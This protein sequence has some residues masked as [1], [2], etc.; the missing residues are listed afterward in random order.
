M[1]LVESILTK[2]PCY[3]AG[4]KID[5]KGLMLHSV[6]CSQPRASAFI[7][8]W[9]SPTFSRACV[10]G[11]IDGNDGTVYQ[12]LPWNHR[13]WHCGSSINGSG[14]NTHIGVEM[15]E[16]ACITYTGGATF[17]CS[18]VDTAKAVAE[19]TYRAAVELFAMLCQKFA[20]D[21]LADGVILSHKEGHSRGIASNHGDPEHL[22]SQLGMGYTMDT[23]RK[24]VKEQMGG[25]AADTKKGTQASV[26]AGLS[27]KDAVPI[28]GELCREDMKKSGVL[29]SVSAAQFI[30]ESGYGKSELGQNANN[31]F[32]MKKS[33]S[34]NTWADSTWDG[35]SVY[36]KK[37]QEQH[38]D[39]TYETITADFRKYPCVED[40]VADHSAYLLGA[41][42]GRSLRYKGIKGMTDYKAVAQIIKD[43]GYATSLTY[44]EKLCNI[45]EKWNLTQYD[46]T[47]APAPKPSTPD[48]VTEFP[49]T[50]FSVKV[51]IDDLNY[52]SEPSMNGKVN[53]QTGKGTFTIMEVRNGGWGRLK[54][55]AG[56]IWLSN[57][58][59]C[60]VGKTVTITEDKKKS[61][62]ELAKE[63]IRGDWGNGTER[64]EKLTAAGHD[65]A[66]IQKRV[67]EML[68]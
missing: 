63:V 2:N 34:G 61:I 57:P 46:V 38:T 4:R 36:T 8:S 66:A 55:G 58:T 22:W 62:D 48:T 6:G 5:V 26:F 67:N 1:K 47:D 60:T 13:G 68:K 20:L 42:N 39:G 21:P 52:R 41:K 29:A 14:N 31:M 27:E 35:T 49:A 50:P 17:K 19:R 7:N 24:A 44:V 59:Y 18:D 33:L 16:P 37:T 65:Y 45:I 28:I 40:S 10:H 30:L 54:S 11:F 43:G 3:T 53:G 9:N 32:G 15:C 25:K 51:I 64:K 56:W 23:F 12:T